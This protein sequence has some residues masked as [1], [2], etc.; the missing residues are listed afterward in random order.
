MSQN[1][2]DIFDQHCLNLH[3]A[4]AR[5]MPQDFDFLTQ[6][7]Q[8]NLLE[9]LK[10]IKREFPKITDLKS[11]F[12]Q[13]HE[14]NLLAIEPNQECIISHLDLHWVNDLPGY[15]YQIQRYLWPDGLFLGSLFG[16][17]TL[18]E[19][20]Q[21]LMAVELELFGGVS[22]RVSPFVTMQDMGALMQRAEFALPVIDHEIIH[23]TYANIFD[24]IT[25]LRGMGMT[26]AIKSRSSRYL[27]KS[28]W[29]KVQDYYRAHFSNDRSRLMVSFEVIYLIGWGPSATQQKPLRPGSAQQ[30]LAK[31][32]KTTEIKLPEKAKSTR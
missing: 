7:C 3:R 31:A 32:L 4:R 1:E 11:G 22:P 17:E 21:S 25:D 14:Y 15:L 2:R 6:H 28:F 24:L 27:G 8:K 19:L 29:P 30:S 10:D 5:K 12:A 20:R 16:G 23:V 26:N 18:Y 9:R 13:Q